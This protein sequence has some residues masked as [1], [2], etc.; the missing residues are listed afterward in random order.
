MT[1]PIHNFDPVELKNVDLRDL[2]APDKRLQLIRICS[3]EWGSKHHFR[4][5]SH[6][7]S[8]LTF[9]VGGGGMAMDRGELVPIK[10]GDFILQ[11]RSQTHETVAGPE[12]VHIKLV[13]IA[14]KDA[15]I[16]TRDF[17]SDQTVVKHLQ[18]PTEVVNCWDQMFHHALTKDA[19]SLE[20]TTC[21]LR[22]L[23]LLLQ[24]S[25]QLESAEESRSYQHFIQAKLWIHEH[26]ASIS[27]VN[28]LS[29][30]MNLSPSYLSRI[31]K[32]HWGG[33]T[34]E[35]I[36]REKMELAKHLLEQGYLIK[37]IASHLNY[38]DPF[39]FSKAFKRIVG[40]SPRNHRPQLNHYY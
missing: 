11:S 22:L 16:W 39:T 28:D 5:L 2:P 18:N 1:Y 7:N 30:A 20:L 24:K 31:F 29:N 14:G 3:A 36:I 40:T 4:R 33:S 38:T 26:L 25:V 12:G 27:N 37:E 9:C 35:F 6:P 21:Q 32:Q 17:F 13:E 8:T 19:L 34:H 10:P 15:E 23:L